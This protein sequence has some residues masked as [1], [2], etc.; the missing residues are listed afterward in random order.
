MEQGRD[1]N[2]HRASAVVSH[3][4]QLVHVELNAL[5]DSGELYGYIL[6]LANESLDGGSLVTQ[7]QWHDIKNHLGGIKLYATFLQK[8]LPDG[9][10]REVVNKMLRAI[11]T[12][13][14]QLT[15]IRRG[16]PT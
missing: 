7:Q 11:N 12:L 4:G 9:E 14:D 1:Q 2:S 16:D 3:N 13:T 10:D 8:K 6:H 15:Q 5:N